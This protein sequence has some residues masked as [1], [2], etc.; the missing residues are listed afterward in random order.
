MPNVRNDTDSTVWVE[1]LRSTDGN[2]FV[3]DEV[4]GATVF[5]R[6]ADPDDDVDLRVRLD[7]GQEVVTSTPIHSI[8][9]CESDQVGA[10]DTIYWLRVVPDGRD[11]GV[12]YGRT[13]R[14]DEADDGRRVHVRPGERFELP[15]GS[16]QIELD[17][18]EDFYKEIDP[19]R[20]HGS[21][22]AVVRVWQRTAGIRPPE[23]ARVAQAAAH[24]L[25]AATYSLHR[26][27]SI[28]Q[29]LRSQDGSGGPRG[30]AAL[31]EYLHLVQETIVALARCIALL[32]H[33][34]KHSG[35]DVPRHAVIERHREALKDLRDAYEHIDERAL[36]RAKGVVDER[37]LMIFEHTS[38][39]RDG[40]I[41]YFD[42]KLRVDDLH[43]VIAACRSDIKTAIGGGPTSIDQDRGSSNDEAVLG[44][45]TG[46]PPPEGDQKP[47]AAIGEG[48]PD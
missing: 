13:L 7:P 36:A 48:A 32:D 17:E 22:A 25:D 42:H 33:A 4:V 10:N 19:E 28:G 47:E 31:D 45:P 5:V 27:T 44:T 11:E 15:K 30:V 14:R 39:V 20:P 41:S 21:F 35:F 12:V 26:A 23:L 37:N 34:R 8:A 43:S 46:E 9:I 18:I 40:V 16:V 2:A 3:L 1:G 6:Q 29:L 24:R 38:L